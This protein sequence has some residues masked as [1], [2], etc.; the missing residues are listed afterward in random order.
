MGIAIEFINKMMRETEAANKA[1]VDAFERLHM[2]EL[3]RTW[4]KF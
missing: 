1:A 4:L 2:K 3:L